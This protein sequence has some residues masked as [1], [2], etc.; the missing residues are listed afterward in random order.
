LAFSTIIQRA[1]ALVVPPDPLF[2]LRRD[3]LIELAAR[4][5]IPAS[6]PFR[7]YAVAGG[8]MSYGASL[9]DAYRLAGT[10]CGRI[11]RGE[12]PADLPVQRSNKLRRLS[13]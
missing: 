9:S 13:S 4:Y 11:L 8:L 10:Y 5:A 2:T 3:E 6:Y 7:E 1:G 12:K